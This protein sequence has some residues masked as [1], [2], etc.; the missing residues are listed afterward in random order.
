MAD[1]SQAA[2]RGQGYKGFGSFFTDNVQDMVNQ[3]EE[4]WRQKAP[5][6]PDAV[7][8]AANRVSK[9]DSFGSSIRAQF[10]IDFENFVY[11]NHGAFGGSLR[12]PHAVGHAW[13]THC[14]S[15]PLRFLDRC[16]QTTV[17]VCC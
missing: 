12:E 16:A 13:Q 3:F 10:F 1:T 7:A 9:A 17:Q 6:V 15:Q 8:V 14:E 11:L 5:R 2:S 4:E